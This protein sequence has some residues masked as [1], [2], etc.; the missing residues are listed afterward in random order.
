MFI[1]REKNIDN[2]ILMFTDRIKTPQPLN[3]YL[4]V[5]NIC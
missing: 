5:T 3:P 4:M 2:Q 1:D